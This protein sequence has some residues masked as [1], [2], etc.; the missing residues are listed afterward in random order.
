M[1]DMVQSSVRKE[2]K[3]SFYIFLHLQ[4]IQLKM[5]IA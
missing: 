3:I 5:L 4:P 1:I 2:N